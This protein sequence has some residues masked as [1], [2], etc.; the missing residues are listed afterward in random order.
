M[1]AG[2]SVWQ[3]FAL[4]VRVMMAKWRSDRFKGGNRSDRTAT[5]KRHECDEESEYVSVKELVLGS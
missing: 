1:F 3:F 5:A 2:C 4:K